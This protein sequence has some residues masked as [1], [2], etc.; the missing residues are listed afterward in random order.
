MCC[1]FVRSSHSR[2]YHRLNPLSMRRIFH[3]CTENE[4]VGNEP[5]A[6]AVFELN[7]V[8][9]LQ[10]YVVDTTLAVGPVIVVLHVVATICSGHAQMLCPVAGSA[11]HF[12][13]TAHSSSMQGRYAHRHT[14]RHRSTPPGSC[15]GGS[16]TH[17]M[18]SSSLV[19]CADHL[20]TARVAQHRFHL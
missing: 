7:L 1:R 5:L 13:V 15:W 2:P 11:F 20:D 16:S 8:I 6:R 12:Q 3:D 18:S 17:M 19:F 10:L 9:I 14:R 4:Q